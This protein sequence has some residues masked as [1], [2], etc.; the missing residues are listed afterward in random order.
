MQRHKFSLVLSG[1]SELTSDLADALFEATHG[2]IELNMRDGA[3]FVEVERAA[4]SQRD[5]ISTAI[6]DI[7][8]VGIEARISPLSRS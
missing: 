7:E 6:D 4:G 8:R 3:A 5:A 1:V 2:E